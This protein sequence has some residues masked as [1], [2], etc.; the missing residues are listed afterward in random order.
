MEH[1]FG[2][3]NLDE[4][5][6]R[7]YPRNEVIY[8]VEVDA[9]YFLD[10]LQSL[11]ET[12]NSEDPRTKMQI[13]DDIQYL[14][15]QLDRFLRVLSC[16]VDYI[17]ILKRKINIDESEIR[18][19]YARIVKVSQNLHRKCKS[20]ICV[21]ENIH[22][23]QKLIERF[24]PTHIGSNDRAPLDPQIEIK[25]ITVR[26]LVEKVSEVLNTTL[27][28][29]L[30]L[31][32]IF[33]YDHF[34]HP[35]TLLLLLI[36]KYYTPRPIMMTHTEYIR[37]KT[38]HSDTRRKRIIELLR[39]WIDHRPNDFIGDSD[40]LGLLVTFLDS[41]FKF[42]KE[43]ATEKDF[44]ELFDNME[45]L[46]EKSKAQ[47]KKALI[48]PISRRANRTQT[49]LNLRRRKNDGRGIR[50]AEGSLRGSQKG[51]EINSERGSDRE[52]DKGSEKGSVFGSERGSVDGDSYRRTL[53]PPKPSNFRSA[54]NKPPPQ[55][56]QERILGWDANE[57]AIQLTLIDQKLFRKI[58]ISHM[59]LKRWTN[60]ECAEQ[61]K[62]VHRAIKRFNSVSFWI[63][64]VIVEAETWN[65]RFL[66]LNK[67]I[68]VARQC[69]K[70]QNYTTANSIFSALFK[71]QMS[72]IWVISKNAQDDWNKLLKTFRNENF[73]QDMDK[74]FHGL[75]PPA[76]PSI[77]F[78]TK[79]FFRFQDNVTFLIKL[80]NPNKY[81]KCSQLYKLAGYC[82][83]VRKFQEN[84]YE[85]QKNEEMYNFLKKEYK[86]K[87][88]INFD[89][90]ETEET[91]REKILSLTS[92]ASSDKLH[93]PD[94]FVFNL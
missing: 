10:S 31:V 77:S 81:L 3:K 80:D 84:P 8:C 12:L 9:R 55:S 49:L 23:L 48:K 72:K 90:D 13:I 73:F 38:H 93:K 37:F 88:E 1:I 52:S 43:D 79:M 51:S 69:L 47:D 74:V 33:T 68:A 24:P 21:R 62:D 6:Y 35:L 27:A 17:R 66:L 29:R 36:K 44:L 25:F 40:L 63:Q 16:S 83:L 2:H 26:K 14:Q 64:Y 89:D 75:H 18:G 45:Q 87:S 46:I 59:M 56:D 91:L 22:T 82:S 92:R 28:E 19:L 78:F 5:F 20:R 41:I 4:S 7:N 71:L 70:I 94:D 32:T 57:M 54:R 65:D 34:M 85:F 50:F 76:V 11:I 39:F 61:C 42:E 60:P 67:F 86:M 15:T 58:Q 53:L 30:K